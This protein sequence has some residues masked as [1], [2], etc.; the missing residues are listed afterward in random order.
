MPIHH[1]PTKTNEN[2]NESAKQTEEGATSNTTP[3][4]PPKNP[5]NT[6][7]P[8]NNYNFPSSNEDPKTREERMQR[9]KEE[10]DKFFGLNTPENTG[11]IPKSTRENKFEQSSSE[12][13]SQSI[14]QPNL[15]QKTNL[16]FPTTTTSNLINHKPL[17]TSFKQEHDENTHHY[18][19][20]TYYNERNN[21]K[22]RESFLRRLRSVSKFNG[23]SYQSLKDFVETIDTLYISCA[24]EE[25]HNELYEHMIL[26]LRGEAR[27][28]VLNLHNTDW[29]TIKQTLLKH[30]DYLSN[31]NI[32]ASQLENLH[33]EK[34]ETLT[35]YAKRT[36]KLLSDKNATYNY[37]TE[38]LR[39]EHNRM[40][41]RSFAKGIRDSKIR[42]R[43]I[44]RGAS[45]L[46]DAIAYAIESENDIVYDIP[47]YELYCR[48]CNRNGHRER[49]C[50]SRNNSNNN[51]NNDLNSLLSA[52]RSMNTRP[53][54]ND[55][56]NQNN[57]QNYNRNNPD[58]NQYNQYNQ[59]QNINENN[60]KNWNTQQRSW[61]ENN[62]QRENNYNDN[63]QQNNYPSNRNTNTNTQRQTTSPA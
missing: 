45:S 3:N 9:E 2:Q 40:A 7:N 55:Y 17:Q 15:I 38:D 44:T 1:S 4:N 23:Y 28:V 36:R 56:N 41:R 39:M 8:D 27:H 21:N 35:E 57:R 58:Y 5:N 61:N 12:K 46:E 49:D 47:K 24:N 29:E 25:E 11:T 33:Q 51:H 32:L 10:R 60:T 16:N 63:N 22:P 52:L 30:F 34:D 43:L 37:L 42:D 62:N 31:K 18:K 14:K 26:Q 53:P 6:Y 54:R 13:S 50:Y 19:N 20:Y 48:G 59:R